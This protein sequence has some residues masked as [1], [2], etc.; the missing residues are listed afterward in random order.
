M[1]LATASVIACMPFISGYYIRQFKFLSSGSMLP[2]SNLKPKLLMSRIKNKKGEA[3]RRS[4]L[5]PR[6][7]FRP[8]NLLL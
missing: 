7:F 4:D 1:N 5:P 3:N 8:L 6:N 2:M